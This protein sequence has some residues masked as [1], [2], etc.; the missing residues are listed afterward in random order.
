M[1]RQMIAV[2]RDLLGTYNGPGKGFELITPQ[3]RSARSDERT[4]A[5]NTLSAKELKMPAEAPDKHMAV[6]VLDYSLYAQC[7]M[8]G[9]DMMTDDPLSRV[10]WVWDTQYMKPKWLGPDAFLIL[11]N[12]CDQEEIANG[13]YEDH[14]PTTTVSKSYETELITPIGKDVHGANLYE[15][16]KY[17]VKVSANGLRGMTDSRGKFQPYSYQG[18]L[19]STGGTGGYTSLKCNAA[20]WTKIEPKDVGLPETY[21]YLR[22]ASERGGMNIDLEVDYVLGFSYG[23][24]GVVDPPIKLSQW[25]DKKNPIPVLGGD[26]DQADWPPMAYVEWTDFQAPGKTA[27]KY[28]WWA[29]DQ[30]R[31][32][33]SIQFGC[34]GG[35]GRTGTFLGAMYILAGV[36]TDMK[37]A[38]EL[39]H[40]THCDDAIESK[41]QRDWLENLALAVKDMKSG[42]TDEQQ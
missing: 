16:N 12:D 5:L 35:H 15:P 19:S 37:S 34:V 2:K 10:W 27:Q 24:E 20:H 4:K 18:D 33:K 6:A 29:F 8:C 22:A 3:D 9:Y 42:A 40:K 11:C 1:R 25:G 36:A 23:W 7:D 30:W 32:G 13:D 28:I 17:G 21:G 26:E 41:A 39:V 38:E 14:K 31:S